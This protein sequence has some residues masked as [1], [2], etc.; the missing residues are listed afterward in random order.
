MNH[1]TTT[2]NLNTQATKHPETRGWFFGHF[3]D[4]YPLFKNND[5]ELKWNTKKKGDQKP[6]KK[7]KESKKTFTILIEGKLLIYFPEAN[8][9]KILS[10]PGDF[11]FY[12]TKDTDHESLALE[13]ST[14]LTVRTPSSPN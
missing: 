4:A 11:V 5:V 10:K 1:V 3:M 14:V 2:G 6:G 8:E 13:D 9:S 7:T 12:D